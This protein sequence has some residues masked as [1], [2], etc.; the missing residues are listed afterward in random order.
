MTEADKLVEEKAYWVAFSRIS[1]LGAARMQHLVRHF[2]S[3]SNA[4]QAS[5]GEILFAGLPQAVADE[6]LR[7]RHQV[8]PLKELAALDKAGVLALTIADVDY[9]ENLR[10]IPTLP[11]VLYMRG[12]LDPA[13]AVAVAVVGTRKPSR[14]GLEAT[15]RIVTDLARASITIVSGLALGIDAAAHEACLEAGGRTLA[16]LGS[17]VDVIYPA[18]HASLARRI[19]SQGA[20]L[21]E[22]PLGTKPDARNFPPR[23]RIISGLSRGVLIVEAG[24]RSGALITAQFALDQNRDTYA[25]PGGIFWPMSQGTNQLIQ[26]GEAKLVTCAGDILEEMDMPLAVA[27]V[28]ARQSIPPGSNEAQVLA[29]LSHD[30]LHVDE[31]GRTTGL[32]MSVVS[33]TL[34]LLELKG[35]VRSLGGMNYV[36]AS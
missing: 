16:V 11:A 3:L 21:S 6:I 2:G 22:Y 17:G 13:D 34:A 1:G 29:C 10:N 12:S 7:T 27:Q 8:D 4:W 5:D 20:L 28:Q 35:M 32:P 14:Y 24:E 36:L 18:K 15:R 26:R 31:L 19:A 9:P 33:S 30:P 23:N 25:V